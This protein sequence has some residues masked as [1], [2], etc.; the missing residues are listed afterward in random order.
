MQESH[1]FGVRCIGGA[2]RGY[3][4]RS[5]YDASEP[6]HYYDVTSGQ[7]KQSNEERRT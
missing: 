5:Q 3:Q 4:D 2:G 6:E 1:R 7:R